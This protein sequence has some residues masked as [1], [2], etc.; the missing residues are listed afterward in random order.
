MAD[1]DLNETE[2][3]LADALFALAQAR[4]ELEALREKITSAR[5]IHQRCFTDGCSVCH[6]CHLTWP[7]PTFEALGGES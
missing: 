2:A 7:C 1:T 4:P 3:R 5:A 6:G